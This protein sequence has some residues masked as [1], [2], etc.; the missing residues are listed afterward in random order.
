MP[1]FTTALKYVVE[2]KVP[3]VAP[4]KV[5]VVLAIVVGVV[6]AASEERCHATTAPVC[7][8][9]FKFAGLVPEQRD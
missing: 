6:K 8:D 7:P 4:V 2:V 5:V 1:L 3:I 9:K